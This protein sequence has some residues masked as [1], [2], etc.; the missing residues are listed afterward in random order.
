MGVS[1]NECLLRK[2]CDYLNLKFSAV[3][4]RG[5]LFRP[6][7]V[8][9][10]GSGEISVFSEGFS[11]SIDFTDG[12]KRE[13]FVFSLKM[14][15]GGDRAASRYRVCEILEH[16]CR[17]LRTAADFSAGEGNEFLYFDLAEGTKL[18]SRGVNG[19]ELYS[20]KMRMRFDRKGTGCGLY[21]VNVTPKA[22]QARFLPLGRWMSLFS[23]KEDPVI[24]SWQYLNRGNIYREA[25]GIRSSLSFKG[26]LK[27]SDEVGTFFES[28][29]RK[30]GAEAVTSV[31]EYTGTGT[32]SA[33]IPCSGILYS[34]VPEIRKIVRAGKESIIEG[35]I[36]FSGPGI[37]SVFTPAEIV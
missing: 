5:L 13:S 27:D 18:V 30:T 7:Q 35:E 37:S 15:T 10:T 6:G 31:A 24:F 9:K 19:D 23:E 28:F 16:I 11:D 20:A 33:G 26:Y 21:F 14:R 2:I 8:L 1:L 36:L 17:S 12:G 4:S 32:P 3:L 22:S 34:A 29:R 25:L